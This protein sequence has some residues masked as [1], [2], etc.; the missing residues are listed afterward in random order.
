MFPFTIYV[1][2]FYKTDFKKSNREG[3]FSSF[4]ERTPLTFEEDQEPI[5][6]NPTGVNE[7]EGNPTVNNADLETKRNSN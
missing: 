7:N 1:L 6:I 4:N 3:H 2:G 5:Q